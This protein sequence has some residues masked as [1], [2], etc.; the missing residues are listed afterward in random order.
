MIM[1]LSA[2]CEALC[3]SSNNNNLKLLLRCND[4]ENYKLLRSQ[5]Q[6]YIYI[7][8]YNPTI[9]PPRDFCNDQLIDF[10]H[11]IT[12]LEKFTSRGWSRRYKWYQ[13]GIK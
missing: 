2:I 1:N 8:I 3:N 4:L 13:G 10:P 9:F 11:P 5:H 6:V 7:Y 12:C